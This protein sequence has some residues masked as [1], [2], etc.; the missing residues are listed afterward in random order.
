MLLR[1]PTARRGLAVA[2]AAGVL[3]TLIHAA[4]AP[5]AQ[6]APPPPTDAELAA[7][8]TRH[9]L[10]AEQ[11][12]FVLPDRFANGDPSNDTAGI[13]GGPLDHGHDPTDEGFYH[14]G[15]LRGLIEN[16][17]YIEGLGTTAIWMAPIFENKPVQGE[18]ENASAGYHGYWITDFTRV[19]PHFGTNEELAELVGA[20]H[21]RDIKV[22]FDVITNH[23]ADVIHYDEGSY[24]YLSKGAFPYLDTEGRPFDDL[25]HA[26]ADNGE[27]PELDVES[28]PYTPVT[29][30]AEAD[31]KV[32]DWLNDPTLY[33][34]RGDSSFA[35][36]SS[37]YGDF[38]GLDDL[39]TARPE[40]VEGMVE[41][42]R[43]WVEDFGIDGFRIDT[44]KHV[45]ME[46][47]TRWAA[48]MKEHAASLG[49]EDF[50]M[51]GEVYSSDVAEKARYVTEGGL[52]ATLDFA[53]QEA[54]RSFASQGGSAKRLSAL[55]DEDHRYTTA[56][57]NA[58]QS[59][60]FLGN[61][62]M[63]R[64]GHFLRADNP[65]AD[66]AELL[67]RS[68]LAHELMFL[69][70]GNPVIYYGDEQGFT[71]S[72]GDKAARATLFGST[73]PLYL[74]DP[75]LGTDRTHAEDAYD[76]DHPLYRAIADLSSLTREHPALREGAQTERY[77]EDGAG[78]WAHTRT[79]A[80]ER[81][82]YLV[83]ANNAEAERTVTVPTDTPD[84]A[85]EVL[86]GEAA[87]PRAGVTADAD[88]VVE[89]TVPALSTVVLRADRPLP[90]PRVA[91]AIELTAPDTGAHGV[92][93]LSAAVTGGA[94][95][96][97]AFAAQVGDGDWEV[98]GV[99]D[100]PPHRVTHTVP[101]GTPEGT[102][103][104]YR[105]VAVDSSGATAATGA[106]T[107]AG[108][109]PPE[110]APR[111]VEREWAV[112]HYHRPD[113]N[114]DDWSLWAWGDLHESE[115]FDEWPN[116][117]PFI[118]RDAFGAF[119]WVRLAPNASEVGYLI[120]DKEGNKDTDTDRTIDL[121][122]TGEVWV[123]Q[124]EPEALNE[125]PEGV[126]P[127][128]DESLAV[129]RYHRPDG[130]YDGWGVHVW[131]G[132]AQPT[133][134][135][136][137]IPA[138]EVDSFGA[139]YEI[140]LA[141][142]A[143][144]LS[145]II[146][147]GDEKDLP[148][149]QSL[150]LRAVG[151]E[152][153]IV[154]GEETYLLPA[155]GAAPE[156]NPGRARAHWIDAGTVVWPGAVPPGGSR[157]LLYH[158]EGSIALEDG[159]LTDEGHWIRLIPTELTDEQRARFPHLAD[160]PALRVDPRDADR[161]E[162][163]LRSQLLASERAANGALTRLTGVQIPGILDDLYAEGAVEADLGP[164]FPDAKSPGKSKGKG[165]DKG[166][167]KG[168]RG[169]PLLSVWAPTAQRVALE[170]DGNEKKLVPMTRDDA[171]GVWSVKGKKN[172]YGKTYRYHVTVWA[173]EAG[174]VVTNKVTDPYSVGLTTDSEYSLIID[175]NDPALAPQG[176]ANRNVPEP[177]DLV[178]A[179]IQ[180]IHVRDFSV[181]DARARNKGKYLA[182]TEHGSHGMQ[183]LRR[184]AEAG[185][186]HA[187]LLPTYDIGSVPERAADRREPDCDLAALPADS[188]EQQACVAE[189][190]DR[191]AYNWGYDPVHFNVPEGSYATD[192]EGTARIVEY[193]RM[194]QGLHAAGLLVVN[195]V[196]YNHT[197][198]SGQDDKSILDRVVPGYYHRLL[199]DGT[200]ADS[201]CCPN[202]AP[203]HAMMGRLV[204]D[205]VVLWAEHYGIDG[206]RFDLMGHHPKQNLLDVREALDAL[207]VEQH[208]VDGK[209]VILYGEGWNFGE[210]A[211]NA[212]FEQATQANMAGTGIATFSDRARDAVRG[213]GPF[214]ED[215]GVQGFASGLYSDPNGSP[216]NGTQAEQ[217]ERL[218]NYQDLVKV[219]LT[220][221]LADYSFTGSDGER[222]TGAEVDYNGSPAGYAAAPGEAVAYVDKHDNET[223]FDALAYKLPDR[224][225]PADRARSQVVAQS[226]ALFSQGPAFGQAG[227]DLLR[228][229]SLDRNSYNSGDW[230]N[231]IH[232]DCRDGN[233]FGR[234][235]PPAW[236]NEAKWPFAK[237]LLTHPNLTVGCAE[238]RAAGDAYRDLLRIRS[239]EDAFG[240]R[241]TEEVQEAVSFPLSGT[242]REIPGVIVMEVGDLA[243]VFNATPHRQHQHHASLVGKDYRLHPI[244]AEGTDEV[245]R[246][247]R[248]V[249]DQ[250]NF[251]I[252]PRTTA[253][254]T[255]R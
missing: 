164:T 140:P 32:P 127:P 61:H 232:W 75:Q 200:V 116:G 126:Y 148:A 2:T 81:V 66:D 201:T 167:K 123:E 217:R 10:T 73:T 240:L 63:G 78:V 103:L 7:E 70:R 122:A 5:A 129:L 128:A 205:S 171:T 247:A 102:P 50:F 134:W 150:D 125:A 87:G 159:A 42:Y 37:L 223:L 218:L 1:T 119:A 84:A 6:A 248:F 58:Q 234:G 94:L 71:G 155:A 27:F 25:D 113:G 170:L 97:V 133:D 69:S 190:R 177:V 225:S 245:V 141:E 20:A 165:E 156:L 197:F 149:D 132:A 41:I 236:D 255:R 154:S 221:N 105:A 83:A 80:D 19:D 35:G 208:G 30:D 21:E 96:R 183:H 72:G 112:V 153:W 12:Y 166:K 114:Y 188:P 107:T 26:G 180:E 9:A 139:V 252:P 62:D 44:V 241:T 142:G 89:L 143:T 65:D 152:V 181:A 227:T 51:F 36:E 194:V 136:R 214:D 209:S 99:S 18:G 111:A 211:D 229:K 189:V 56:D 233:G 121:S 174:A 14:G 220:G 117:R 3:A 137:P 251:E 104:R 57:T 158:P 53:F 243:V 98:L 74:Q 52:N 118:G 60:T 55:F 38:Y 145:Y 144:S 206:F 147:R 33:H 110:Q 48:A 108:S 135:S 253:V 231:A 93:E 88:G 138:S 76:T 106:Q 15:D 120:V 82:E 34:N 195:D 163:A 31:V 228:S 160:E 22:F 79:D 46:F 230:F 202:T 17:D 226:T 203:E 16:L 23:T 45:N 179:T 100:A 67:G 169:D 40:V 109:P 168:H 8:P 115:S 185:T 157:Q 250:G 182:F 47:W 131:T 130:D 191:D 59:V 77:A 244:Q 237:S 92:V 187:H 222:V 193:R 207:T 184:L 219:G 162:E 242:D 249:S 4:A 224:V 238:I 172:W 11:F 43:T 64:I 101:T 213:G 235:L 210:V 186:T 91:P 54:T 175:L 49:N 151:H 161:I 95:N 13:P 176:W 90:D 39:F 68:R 24:D 212:R 196:V 146:H 246:S 239:G 85:F 192:P 198:A 173:P 254:F 28:F 199:A 178:D 216:A 86:Y 29:S 215:P 204:V 124:G